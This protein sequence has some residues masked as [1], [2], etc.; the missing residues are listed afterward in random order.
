MVFLKGDFLMLEDLKLEIE[1]ILEKEIEFLMESKV[2]STSAFFITPKE[3]YVV[4]PFDFSDELKAKKLLKKI[5]KK[6]QATTV[7][8]IMYSLMTKLSNALSG[9]PYIYK[10][11]IFAYGETKYDSFGI[12]QEFDCDKNDKIVLGN[13]III[14]IGT[15]SMTG[16]MRRKF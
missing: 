4:D 3:L 8:T 7:I 12:A 15:G 6:R 16:F 1:T 9:P 10:K 11:V 13:R 2:P 14:P 5:A